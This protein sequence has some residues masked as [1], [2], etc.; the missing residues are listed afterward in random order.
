MS[1]NALEYKIEYGV[2]PEVIKMLNL[3]NCDSFYFT[4][5]FKNWMC[6]QIVQ[7]FE[8]DWIPNHHLSHKWNLNTD[9]PNFFEL[10]QI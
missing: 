4:I 7:I 9:K 5:E 10:D 6:V 3:G 1:K 2:F 8:S